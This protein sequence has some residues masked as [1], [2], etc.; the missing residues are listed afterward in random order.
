MFLVWFV[1]TGLVSFTIMLLAVRLKYS[2]SL[3]TDQFPSVGKLMSFCLVCWN[4]VVNFICKM[5]VVVMGY[6]V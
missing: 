6:T 2:L 1:E 5:P 3:V 4:Y